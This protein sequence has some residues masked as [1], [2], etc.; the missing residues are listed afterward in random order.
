MSVEPEKKDENIST[1]SIGSIDSVLDTLLLAFS[2]PEEPVQPLPPPLIMLGGKL[3]PGISTTSI[4]ANVITRQAEAG[5]PTGDVFADGPNT[6]EA[7]V[8]IITEEIIKSLLNE[9]VV[10]VVIDPGISVMSTGV[11]NL[12]APVISQG[13]TTTWGTGNGIIR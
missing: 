1:E 8:K 4:V 12:G 2:L 5:L 9:C 6:T 13:F 7:L 11:G 10:N 3:R